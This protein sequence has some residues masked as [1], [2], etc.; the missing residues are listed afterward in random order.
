M[1]EVN[2]ICNYMAYILE[3]NPL[4]EKILLPSNTTINKYSFLYRLGPIIAFMKGESEYLRSITAVDIIYHAMFD[5][6]TADSD[7]YKL[8]TTICNQ[9]NIQ[10]QQYKDNKNISYIALTDILIKIATMCENAYLCNEEDVI[11]YKTTSFNINN[12]L[13]IIEKKMNYAG[14]FSYGV[15]DTQYNFVSAI[16]KIKFNYLQQICFKN[17]ENYRYTYNDMV[18]LPDP[19]ETYMIYLEFLLLTVNTYNNHIKEI[20]CNEW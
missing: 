6:A 12:I 13:Y 10:K 2:N 4:I 9:I 5:S 19:K 7:L 18:I 15:S 1:K 20:Y 17:S 11:S 16:R 3:E 14:L 8:D